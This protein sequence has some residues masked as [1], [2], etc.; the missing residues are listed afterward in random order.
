MEQDTAIVD[1]SVEAIEDQQLVE[2]PLN[3]LDC[4]AGGIISMFL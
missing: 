2:I 1:S 4:V 3:A